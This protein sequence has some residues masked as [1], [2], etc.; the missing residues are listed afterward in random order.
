[1]PPARFEMKV[2]SAGTALFTLEEASEVRVWVELAHVYPQFAPALASQTPTVHGAW[3]WMAKKDLRA[4]LKEWQQSAL[5]IRCMLVG[6]IA[7]FTA[8]AIDEE[9]HTA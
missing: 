3:V 6:N 7:Y 9:T 1:M 2:C 5:V 8:P 4:L